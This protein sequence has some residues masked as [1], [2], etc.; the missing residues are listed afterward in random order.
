MVPIL[1]LFN[2]TRHPNRPIH[3]YSTFLDLRKRDHW[4][5]P[6]QRYR[7][8]EDLLASLQEKVIT[9]AEQKA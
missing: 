2:D 6:T 3:E 8:L 1:P 9:P 5:L 4:V 7:D